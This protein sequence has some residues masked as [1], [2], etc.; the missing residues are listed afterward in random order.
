MNVYHTIDGSNGFSNTIVLFSL[1]IIIV[2]F[3]F[4]RSVGATF[5]YRHNGRIWI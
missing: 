2:A 5:V 3:E 1:D 4:S